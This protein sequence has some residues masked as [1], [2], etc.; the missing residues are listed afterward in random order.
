MPGKSKSN[1]WLPIF[2]IQILWAHFLQK[3]VYLGQYTNNP[4]AGM[5]N[6]KFPFPP[7]RMASKFSLPGISRTGIHGKFPRFRNFPNFG[8]FPS[9]GN[10]GNSC[11]KGNSYFQSAHISD[12]QL[13]FCIR[14]LVLYYF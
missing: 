7:S 8:N 1:A 5:F 3:T 6:G 13:V 11:P 14:K 10:V 4:K 2:A 9:C 12:F